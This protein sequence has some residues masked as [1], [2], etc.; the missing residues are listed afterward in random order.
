MGW[1]ALYYISGHILWGDSLK[2][3]PLEI[4]LRVKHLPTN[5]QDWV[6]GHIRFLN[7]TDLTVKRY[8]F[9]PLEFEVQAI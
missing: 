7:M 2:L 8:E 6:V 4:G 9:N 5:H 1:Y 3:K